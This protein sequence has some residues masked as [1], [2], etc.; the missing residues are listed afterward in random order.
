MSLVTP[1][2]GLVFWMVLV[3]GLLFFI[4]AKAG[5]PAVTNMVEK[6]TEGIRKA[7]RDAEVAEEKVRGLAREQ[8]ELI[9]K[10]RAEQLKMLQEASAEK[11]RIIAEAK[12]QAG[13]EASKI[14]SAARDQIALERDNAVRDIRRQVADLS[15][16]VA[17]KVLRRELDRQG[18]QQAYAE[19]LA[20]ELTDRDLK[21]E[22]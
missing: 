17:E 2:I 3:F 1:D 7:L 22:V 12:V 6:R 9:E 11:E 18:G 10:T 5:F 19:K 14:L 4:L 21:Q 15:V 13:E 8:E 16:A 20:D